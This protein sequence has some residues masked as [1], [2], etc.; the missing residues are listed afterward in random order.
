VSDA[1]IVSVIVPVRNGTDCLPALLAALEGQTLARAQFEVLVVDDGSTDGTPDL[2]RRSPVARLVTRSTSGGSYTARNDGVMAARGEVLAFTDADCVPTATWLERGLDAV[3]RGHRLVGGHVEVPLGERPTAAAL[4]DAVRFLDQ[5]TCVAKGFGVTANL[6]LTRDVLRRVGPFNDRLRSGG[7]SEFGHR[8]RAAGESVHYAAD[9]TIVHEPRS[10]RRELARKGYRI[11]AANA[12]QRKYAE[13]Q[14]RERALICA[15]PGNW[16]P[17]RRLW[18]LARLERRGVAPGIGRRAAMHATQYLWLQ[19][20]MV[21]GSVV[22]S[23]RVR[24]DRGTDSPP[25][26]NAP[27]TS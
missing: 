15:Q 2:V 18:G 23:V 14:L 17:R 3:R 26:V 5:E 20:P 27:E 9:V 1:P 7:D 8:A 6:W 12:A 13:G 22:G 16:L 10:T 11:G 4:V 19:L 24:R 25:A 21:W